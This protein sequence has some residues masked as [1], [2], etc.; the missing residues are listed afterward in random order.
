MQKLFYLVNCFYNIFGFTGIHDVSKKQCLNFL[1][2][3]RITLSNFSLTNNNRHFIVTSSISVNGLTKNHKFTFSYKTTFTNFFIS[4]YS[5][6]I[7]Q[8]IR[9]RSFLSSFKTTVVLLLRLKHA[10][11]QTESLTFVSFPLKNFY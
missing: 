9:R 1:Y 3:L 6:N 5:T 8:K 11:K 4:N 10:C 2:K 7:R